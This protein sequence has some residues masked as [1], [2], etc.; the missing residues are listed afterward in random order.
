MSKPT[1]LI[2]G[3]SSGIGADLA[4]CIARDGYNLILVARSEAAMQT[5]ADELK[6]KHATASTIIRLDLAKPGAGKT[7]AELVAA[8]GLTVD[9]LVNNAGFGDTGPVHS[10]DADKL[11]QMFQLNCGTLTDLTRQFLPGM[12]ERGHGKV[13]NV[14]STAAFQPMPQWAVYSASKAYVL[15]F[16]EAVAEEMRG[17]GVTITALCPGATATNFASAAEAT[18]T[19]LFSPGNLAVM[20]SI[21]V[22]KLGWAGAKAGRVVVITGQLNKLQAIAGRHLPRRLSGAVASKLLGG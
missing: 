9:V 13:L 1:A 19:A 4:R 7:L 18:A 8:K 22:A 16:S 2:T 15:A 6:S 21:K 14:A 17:T 20:S 11:T 10:S 12:V 5:L 3:A